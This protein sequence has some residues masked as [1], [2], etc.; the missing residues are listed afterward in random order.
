MAFEHYIHTGTKRLRCGY[1]T[2]SCATLAAKA[3]TRMLFSGEMVVRESI[4]TPSGVWVEVDIVDP[5][6]TDDVCSC[7]VRKDAGDDV[8]VTDGLLIY[9]AIRRCETP[10]V[11]IVGGDGV[12]RVTKPGLEQ[13]VGEAA[14]NRVPRQMIREEVLAICQQAGERSGVEVTIF[15]PEGKEAAKKTFNPNLGVVEGISILGTTGIVEPRSLSA[16][17]DSIALEIRQ[18]AALG[19]RRLVITPGNYGQNFIEKEP[20]LRDIPTVFCANFI[21]DAL[22]YAAQYHYTQVLLVGHIGKLVKVAGGI[23]NTH[24]RTADCRVELFC[25]HAAAAGA[26]QETILA[27]FEA[28]TSDACLDVLGEEGLLSAVLERL[29]KAIGEHLSRRVAGAYAVG[30]IVFSNQRGTLC[31]SPGVDELLNAMEEQEGS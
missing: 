27:L 31:R 15:V 30:A 4:R 22:D 7:A 21:G 25:A 6:M 26:R 24:S 20:R 18:K 12:G 14:I 10:G 28:A 8:D 23:M 29:G 5:V 16:L 17:R 2:G 13:P 19:T 3:A 11:Q 1:T 9:A